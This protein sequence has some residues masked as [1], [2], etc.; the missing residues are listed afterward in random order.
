M[1]LK[2]RHVAERS[3]KSMLN[4]IEQPLPVFDSLKSDSTDSSEFE[5]VHSGGV[6]EQNSSR[7]SFAE[8]RSSSLPE[9]ISFQCSNEDLLEN[10]NDT[11]WH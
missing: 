10:L 4:D 2:S 6:L 8:S 1:D 9:S 5:E 11:A 7:E 3:S